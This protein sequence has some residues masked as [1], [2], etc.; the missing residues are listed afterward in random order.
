[1]AKQLISVSGRA[2]TGI[3]RPFFCEDESGH[4]LF[5]KRGNV[6]WDQLV[7]EY[8]IGNLA[9][10]FGIQVAPFDLVEIS[11][12]LADQSL[13]KD[14]LEFEPGIAFGSVRVPFGEELSESHLRHIPE[15]SKIELLCF[16][17]W[18]GNCDRRLTYTSVS[19]NL[20]WEPEMKVFVAIDHDQC[21]DTE[22]DETEF[23][24]E[25]I[26][27]DVRPYV[28]K[29]RVSE[30]R[31][32]FEK[33]VKSIETIWLDLPKEWTKHSD[34]TYKG[35]VKQLLEPKHSIEAVLVTQ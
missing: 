27:R 31:K 23:F 14:P 2:E 13:V 30:L 17:W 28:D 6:T 22:M 11:E 12:L 1:M 21:L 34:L 32:R 15:W 33:A 35:V 29:Q 19:S 26:F 20:L 16:D 4:S 7:T 9:R 18:V 24:R 3:S 10:E 5:V 25:H 8:V